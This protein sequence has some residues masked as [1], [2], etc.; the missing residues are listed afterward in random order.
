MAIN[1]FSFLFR[2]TC[3]MSMKKQGGH[4]RMVQ[5]KILRLPGRAELP[6]CPE[7]G[8]RGSAALPKT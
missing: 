4:R 7:F 6:L 2:Q 1:N 5:D 8:R 3:H